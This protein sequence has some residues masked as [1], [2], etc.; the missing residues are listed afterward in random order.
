MVNELAVRHPGDLE[1]K[2]WDNDQLLKRWRLAGDEIAHLRETM[3]RIEMELKRRIEED[4]GT[5]IHHPDYTVKIEGAYPVYD[6]PVLYTAKE[7]IPPDEW[8]RLYTP[9]TTKPVPAKINMTL[10]KSFRKY[11]RRIGE[12]LEAAKLPVGPGTLRIKPKWAKPQETLDRDT[13]ELTAK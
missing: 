3:G 1:L 7:Y 5:A 10:L 4:G 13:G 9:A 11:H 12:I 8:D 6:Q 2:L